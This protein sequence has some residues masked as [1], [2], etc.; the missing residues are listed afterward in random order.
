MLD[1]IGHACDDLIQTRTVDGHVLNQALFVANWDWRLPV[2]PTDGTI[3]GQLSA[4]TAASITSGSY[5]Y[6][7]DF[8]GHALA[9][10]AATT[11]RWCRSRTGCRSTPPPWTAS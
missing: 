11:R 1:P 2:A 5:D 4:V 6:G 3:D 8:L 7:V 10:A 9:Q